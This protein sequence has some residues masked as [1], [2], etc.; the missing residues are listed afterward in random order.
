MAEEKI[1]KPTSEQEVIEEGK[2]FAFLGYWWILWVIPVF[3]KK[4][5][6]FALFHGK[7]GLVLFILE[8][9]VWIL[10]FIPII[11]WFIIRPLGSL[12]CLILAIIGMIQALNGKYWKMPL[13]GK[14]AEG[15]KI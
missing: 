2:I 15:I 5:N 14:Y 13:L 7:Q 10:S 3:A 4:E 8:I 11:G 6:H 9:I 1:T 12:L